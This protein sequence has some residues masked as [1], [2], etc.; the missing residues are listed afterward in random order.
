MIGESG[1]QVGLGRHTTAE[2]AALAVA[3]HRNA[4]E[5][6]TSPV[7]AAAEEVDSGD[8]ADAV[9]EVMVYSSASPP[10][11]PLVVH[12]GGHG[13]GAA[14]AGG[15]QEPKRFQ[16]AF[17]VFM[18]ANRENIKAANPSAPPTEVGKIA[19]ELWK[20][21]DEAARAPHV[22]AADADRARYDREVAAFRAAG[23]VVR[24]RKR[25]HSGDGGGEGSPVAAEAGGLQ[26]PKRPNPAF[27]IFMNGA[28]EQIKADH[29]DRLA[30]A[31]SSHTEVGKIAGEMWKEMDEA[32]KEP[33]T[34]KATEDKARYDRELAAFVEAGGVP[35]RQPSQPKPKR[36]VVG[37]GSEMSINESA[38]RGPR[39]TELAEELRSD[40]EAR[41]VWE[42][43]KRIGAAKEATEEDVRGWKIVWKP[44]GEEAAQ[45]QNRAKVGD[46]LMWSPESTTHKTSGGTGNPHHFRSLSAL[47]GALELRV[48]ARRTGRTWLPPAVG[49]LVQVYVQDE[50]MDDEEF[51]WRVAEVRRSEPAL[52]G[53]FQV[54]VRKRDGAPDEMFKEWYGHAD[55]GTDWMRTLRIAGPSA[56]GDA[57]A[58]A[59]PAADAAADEVADAAAD[60]AA[61]DA[62]A[63]AVTP[64]T[65]PP[66]S[67]PAPAPAA[68]RIGEV[69]ALLRSFRLEEYIQKFDDE[70]YDDLDYLRTLPPAELRSVAVDCGMKPGHAA[71]F[72]SWMPTG[73]PPPP[74]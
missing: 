55:E 73:G 45:N 44:R 62:A 15:L 3:R 46:L 1:R 13:G 71:K 16:S 27:F 12:Q 64:S 18:N 39:H 36:H 31:P 70:G 25:R 54:C 61:D 66:P 74:A 56:D 2:E 60:A 6:S 37:D 34:S 43:A 32:A 19:G 4:G 22:A 9:D 23:G 57:A 38:R 30:A 53:R 35:S 8:D 24:G 52:G 7:A 29:P 68:S 72:V 67:T 28:R 42:A 17:F 50:T 63:D 21:M 48:H 11:Y 26:E 41:E 33:Y 65:T 40:D 59:E 5:A 47:H 10:S 14:A 69:E 51:E 58:A 49:E 20:E